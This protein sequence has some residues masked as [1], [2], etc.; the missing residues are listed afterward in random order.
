MVLSQIEIS[1]NN[2]S[3]TK[4]ILQLR[5]RNQ[6]NETLLLRPTIDDWIVDNNLTISLISKLSPP[7]ITLHPQGEAI[8][9]I[10]LQLPSNLRNRQTLRSW[11]RF[12]GIHAPRKS[13]RLTL[14]LLYP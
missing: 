8:Q 6:T 7:F 5:L 14:L 2:T 1:I 12:P 11:L 4:L 10:A 3:E 9:K 13:K